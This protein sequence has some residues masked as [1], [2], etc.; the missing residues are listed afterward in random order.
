MQSEGTFLENLAEDLIQ[1]YKNEGDK[2][3]VVLPSR[4][5]KVFLLEE[6]KRKMNGAAWLPNI[7]S[8]E[9]FIT[10]LSSLQPI[11]D[12]DLIF[13]FYEVYKK[14]DGSKA[15]SLEEFMGWGSILLQDF[16]EIDRN[17]INAEELFGY[18]SEQKAAENWNLGGEE[19]TE[20][21]QKYLAF[22]HRFIHYYKALKQQLV[23]KG[24]AYQGML[25][26]HALVELE[27][28]PESLLKDQ[29]Y[30][31]AGFNALTP[32]EEGIIKMIQHSRK[33]SL[34]W[35][36]DQ[37]YLEDK[38]QEAGKFLSTKLSG[39]QEEKWIGN[40]L[41]TEEKE[42]RIYGISGNVGQAKLLGELLSSSTHEDLRKRAVILADENLLLPV[43]ESLPESQKPLNVTMGYPV[44]QTAFYSFFYSFFQLFQTFKG[45]TDFYYKNLFAFLG[46]PILKCI[47]EE[48][49]LQKQIDELRESQ[50]SFFSQKSL[51]KTID[52]KLN[53]LFD[54][55]ESL[56]HKG[57]KL[58]EQLKASDR[59]DEI[60]LEILF[61]FYKLFNK[62][63]EQEA[64]TRLSHGA[65]FTLYR[66][67]IS[68][69]QL[70]FV[71]EPLNG[72]QIM[73]VL[74][75]RTLDFEEIYLLS[76]N[77]G[78]L[79]SGKSQNSLIPFNLKK[80]FNLPTY[81]EKDAIF[82]YHFY[83]IL[84]R[85]KRV[86][87]IYNSGIDPL[88]GGQKSRFIEQLLVEMPIKNPKVNIKEIKLKPAL[89]LSQPTE[90]KIEKTDQIISLIEAK[91]KSRLSAS[92]INTY[93]S[94]PLDFY[95]KYVLRL[96]EEVSTDPEESMEASQF[97]SILHYSLDLLYAEHTN[98]Q[99]ILSLGILEQMQKKID[100]ALNSAFKKNDLKQWK[101]GKNKLEYEVCR[102]YL[103]QFFK[104]EEQ[105]LKESEIIILGLEDQI[106][107]A[108]KIK[109]AN[110]REIEVKL[111]G[112]IDRIEKADG[113]IQIIDYKSGAVRKSKLKVA[114][115]ELLLT[116]SAHDHDK[117]VQL[118]FYHL[119]YK[120]KYETE[121]RAAILSLK[122]LSANLMFAEGIEADAT[123]QL[124]EEVVNNMLNKEIPLA[125]NPEAKYCKFCKAT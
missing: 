91:I 9:D 55:N 115:W 98:E 66:M 60:E 6:F 58:I 65:L 120:L 26:R 34:Y 28:N 100:A 77:E 31:F 82:A 16:N 45:R 92:A 125:H 111:H 37:Y 56:I 5:A 75:S 109:L 15:D 59:L 43:L 46:S 103:Q 94:C 30:V 110:E 14:L 38:L 1:V 24:W 12:L 108:Q 13:L 93:L 119:L 3:C 42:I 18:L 114:D 80:E 104:W 32:A 70:S 105:R 19:L 17:L 123:L 112:L 20:Y 116:Q 44:K 53:Y 10:E 72:L 90:E 21:Q 107:V 36:A 39:K 101:K 33:T 25:Y 69:S 57:L 4:R 86:H 23:E 52:T 83:R 118:S 7:L 71:G 78:I 121:A 49:V 97:G 50:H 64:K 88:S 11:D 48:A 67:H 68:K 47:C 85:A 95:Y 8:M 89:S 40:R 35:D 73:G 102:T 79:P 117:F 84:Q 76:M 27:K 106:E 96:E 124:I 54:Q 41:L 63:N 22:W 113:Q 74:E 61:H 81:K 99:E 29:Y 87:L 2:L 62:L 122:D 51:E